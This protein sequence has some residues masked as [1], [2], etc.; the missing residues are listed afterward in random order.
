MRCPGRISVIY[1]NHKITESHNHNFN[2]KGSPEKSCDQDNACHM[3]LS[4]SITKTHVM[5]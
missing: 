5:Y 3:S 4:I 1:H 2:H